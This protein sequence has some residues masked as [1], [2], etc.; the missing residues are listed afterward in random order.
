M[1]NFHPY[2]V[3][4]FQLDQI[5]LLSP[6]QV[7]PGAPQPNPVTQQQPSYDVL[8]GAGKIAGGFAAGGPVGAGI[9]AIP[10]VY[11][12]FQGFQQKRK[13]K[14]LEQQRPTYQIPE[15]QTEALETL[16][17]GALD[18]RIPG[19]TLAQEQLGKSSQRSI[20]AIMQSGASPA[21]IIAGIS[22]V[23]SQERSGLEGIGQQAAQI[24][25]QRRGALVQGLG[26]QAQFQQQQQQY[27]VLDPF[28]E[29]MQ[30]KAA[31]EEGSR[32]NIY[33]GLK[34]AAGV[35]IEALPTKSFR[36]G[37]GKIGGGSAYGSDE[38]QDAL[39]TLGY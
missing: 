12:I 11:K 18:P 8:G 13:A 32:Q 3:A 4:N 39:K 38:I 20:E 21:E 23:G 19:Q 34:G 37:A 33:G 6:G 36:E 25:E 2:S 26:T 17:A 22:N 27:N 14:S 28:A 35:G 16:R 5:P 9:A 15:A 31:L 7:F 10:E 30:A 1:I 29:S 24:Q